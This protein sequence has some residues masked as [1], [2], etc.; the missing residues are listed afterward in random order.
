M[1][2]F[3]YVVLDQGRS[4]S[5]YNSC[6]WIVGEEAKTELRQIGFG[7]NFELGP[8]EDMRFT[9]IGIVSGKAITS[10]YDKEHSS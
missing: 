2:I 3:I 1:V 10:T 7:S 9:L 5:S 4:L 6:F 8:N